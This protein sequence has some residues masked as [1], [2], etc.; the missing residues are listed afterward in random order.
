MTKLAWRNIWRNR[1]RTAITLASIAFGLAA[2]LFVQSLIKTIQLQLIEKATGV[3]TGHVQVVAKGVDDYKLPD[4]NIKDIAR[5]VAEL[6]AQ[7]ITPN[8]VI[9]NAGFG[10]VGRTQSLELSDFKRQFETNVF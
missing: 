7:G 8:I 10:V 1:R 4:K 6:G 2:I 3:F 5:V 9:A